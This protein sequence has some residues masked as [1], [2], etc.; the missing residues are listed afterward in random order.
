MSGRTPGATVRA[1]HPRIPGIREVFHATIAEHAYPPHTH[2]AWTL[3]VVDAGSIRYDL[4]RR[5]RGADRAMVSVLP[6]YVVHD[7]RP[8]TSAG[9]H[10]RVLYLEPGV[11]GEDLIGA[12][13]DRPEIPDPG[14][15]TVVGA[16]HDALACPDDALEAEIRLGLL[17]ERIR[18]S[19][20]DAPGSGA[21]NAETRGR[22]A[23]RLR[24]WLDERLFDSV[25]LAAA[26]RDLET[27]PTR[28]ARAFTGAFGLAP[29]AYITG[30]RVHAARDRIVDGMPLAQVAAE[31]GFSDQAHLSRRFRQV[32]GAT[33]GQFAPRR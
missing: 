18:A 9:F 20:G 15:R 21:S 7:G 8:A 14:L 2:D 23:E 31:T 13:V 11:L 19:Y 32:L 4:D 27:S 26:A 22:L 16:L 17:A 28:L 3:F 6:P 10:K 30:R 25:T 5:A 29:H 1:W 12:T 24:A 33:P